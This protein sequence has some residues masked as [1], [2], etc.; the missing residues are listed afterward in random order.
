[1]TNYTTRPIIEGAM[2]TAIT[3]IMAILGTALPV[4]FFLIYI[5]PVPIA[6]NIFRHGLRWGLI[7]IFASS[8]I[9]GS[10]FGI[11]A[12]FSVLL[13]TLF[14]SPALGIGFKRFT[15]A[16]N[17]L[18]TMIASVL[19]LAVT[20]ALAFFLMHINFWQDMQNILDSATQTSMQMYKSM[21]MADDEITEHMGQ[22]QS[23]IKLIILSLPAAIILSAIVGGLINFL[24]TY[25]LLYRLGARQLRS[26]APFAQWRMPIIFLFLFGFSLIGM[27]WGS[28]REI[29]LLY[30]IAFNVNYFS[31][32]FCRLQ[33]LCLL[34]YILQHFKLPTFTKVLI[35]IFVIFT[36]FL[37]ILMYAG[38]FDMIFDYRTRFDRRSYN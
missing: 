6:I 26:L 12:A 20:L 27:Y 29:T 9:T 16:K 10:F 36:P 25:R 24:L 19:S 18:I 31:S 23:M 15:P 22:V 37:E 14:I 35:I 4:F 3:V 17:L 28:T 7:S 5:L 21:G 30:N 11:Y 1:M 33:G 13:A 34:Y 2:L 38:L 8:L 32:M